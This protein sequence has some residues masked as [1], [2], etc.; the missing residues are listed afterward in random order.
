[1]KQCD[2]CDETFTPPR[3]PTRENLETDRYCHK[4]CNDPYRRIVWQI[5]E[6]IG[7]SG[8]TVREYR[9]D[10]EIKRA[11]VGAC[12][13]GLNNTIATDDAPELA[14]DLTED[15]KAIKAALKLAE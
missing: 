5:H 3:H 9:K 1:M 7:A 6:T 15:I 8:Y 13:I 12:K 2:L 11:L 4:C 10:Q 14:I